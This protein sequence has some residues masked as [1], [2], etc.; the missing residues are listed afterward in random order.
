MITERYDD[1]NAMGGQW[2]HNVMM[3]QTHCHHNEY[4]MAY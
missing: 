2:K 4:E 3:M 1:I